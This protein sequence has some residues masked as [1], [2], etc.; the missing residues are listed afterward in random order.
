MRSCALPVVVAACVS[1]FAL[2]PAGVG[3]SIL[4][5]VLR[6][7]GMK[8]EDAVALEEQLVRKPSDVQSRGTLLVYYSVK[9]LRDPNALSARERHIVWLIENAPESAIL[10]L[11]YGRINRILEPEGYDRAKQAWLKAVQELPVSLVALKHASR[12][13]LS[14]DRTL[15]EELLAQGQSLDAKDPEWADSLGQLYSLELKSVPEG[16][17]RVAAA[18][19]AYRQFEKAYELSDAKQ[20]DSL[21]CDLAS[22]ALTA[23][24]RDDAK[25]LARQMVAGNTEERDR[26]LT[27]HRGHLILG[28]IA[29]LDGNVA[30]AKSRL[31]LAGKTLGPPELDSFSLGPNML[32]AKQLLGHGETEAVLEY[33]ELCGKY[34]T[35]GR[36]NLDQW[37]EDVKANRTPQFV[38]Y[39]T[40]ER[41]ERTLHLELSH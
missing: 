21:L 6:A 18:E 40:D 29:L 7:H 9:G 12:F 27:I 26:N 8:R 19:K 14:H 22:T 2:T 1:F 39:L 33:F 35:A 37:T 32:L 16:P 28:R 15:S 11:H 23:G 13:F 4:F 5:P 20:R 30:E 24:L 3:E 31:R 36:L 25:S 17:T 10:G 38:D 41:A 34:W